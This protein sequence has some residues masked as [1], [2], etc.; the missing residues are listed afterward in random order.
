MSDLFD[1]HVP[2]MR[3]WMGDEEIEA[4]AQVIRSGWVSQGPKVAEFENAVA[5]FVG[6]KY[7]VATNACTTALHLALRISGVKYGDEVICPSL[8]CMATANAIHMAGAE[9]RFADVAERT[10]NIDAAS[11]EESITPRTTAILAVHQI[12]LPVEIEQIRAVA[13]RRGLILIE[14][15]AC[16]LGATYKGR[17]V[18]GLGSP[19]SFSFH[20]RKMITSGE[21]GMITTDDEHLAE[22]ARILRSTGASV[23]DLARHQAKGVLV[24]HYDDTGYNYRLTD[25]QAALGLVQMKKIDEMLAQRAAQARRYDRAIAE[26]EHVSP[27]FVPEHM[28]HSYSSYQITLEPG[29]AVSRNE[30]L[31]IMAASG[32]SCRIGIQPLHFEPFYREKLSGLKLPVTEDAAARTIFLPI[33]PGMTEA[34][35]ERVIDV[36]RRAVKPSCIAGEK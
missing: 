26:M 29:C 10:F 16:S 22:Q 20:P 1:G 11:I 31:E 18:G 7:A 8:T 21:G 30:L 2:L 32:V 3:P 24:Q 27:P 28:T 34:E 35:Q 15:G 33:F 13:E 4:I 14:D 6:T 9:P 25:L 5:A 23:S 17:Q 36:L 19:T 12:G